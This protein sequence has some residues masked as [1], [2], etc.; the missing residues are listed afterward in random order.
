MCFM[1]LP[2]FQTL[3]SQTGKLF[4]QK[5][6]LHKH[7]P[8]QKLF[9]KNYLYQLLTFVYKNTIELLQRSVTSIIRNNK[10]FIDTDPKPKII[11]QKNAHSYQQYSL[12]C[13][14]SC[15]TFEAP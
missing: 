5:K 7:E 6:R 14:C 10:L 11:K 3:I 2:C 9:C 12:T 4:T 8:F 13:I 1:Y 15:T